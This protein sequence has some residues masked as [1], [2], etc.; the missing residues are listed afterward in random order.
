MTRAGLSRQV[1]GSRCSMERSW[2]IGTLAQKVVVQC[3][4]KSKVW[5]DRMKMVDRIASPLY[6]AKTQIADFKVGVVSVPSC[7]RLTSKSGNNCPSGRSD[8]CSQGRQGGVS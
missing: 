3:Q 4:L 1:G 2:T 6:A 5:Y 8:A 7:S